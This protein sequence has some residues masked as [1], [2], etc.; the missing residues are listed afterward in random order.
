MRAFRA[1]TTWLV[2]L[3]R[4]LVGPCLPNI[5]TAAHPGDATVID[6]VNPLP[7]PPLINAVDERNMYVDAGILVTLR[8]TW[9]IAVKGFPLAAGWCFRRTLASSQPLNARHCLSDHR[10]FVPKALAPSGSTSYPV[11]PLLYSTLWVRRTFRASVEYSLGDAVGG[12]RHVLEQTRLGGR[13]SRNYPE[14]LEATNSARKLSIILQTDAARDQSGINIPAHPRCIGCFETP[15]RSFGV[16]DYRVVVSRRRRSEALG[17]KTGAYRGLEDAAPILPWQVVLGCPCEGYMPS[18]S[19]ALE[20][21]RD[22][23]PSNTASD[24]AFLPRCTVRAGHP[25]WRSHEPATFPIEGYLAPSRMSCCLCGPDA[26]GRISE[27]REVFIGPI[28]SSSTA[29]V[30]EEQ[31]RSRVVHGLPAG[32]PRGASVPWHA[33]RYPP[34]LTRRSRPDQ[35]G[36][37]NPHADHCI[38]VCGHGWG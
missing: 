12:L 1:T 20:S 23:L 25:P 33:T 26:R 38:H 10:S 32:P 17:V 15:I 6:G 5:G 7:Q 16:E 28:R 18:D 37:I 36:D 21:G 11:S 2:L 31:R 22:G 35:V 19:I 29:T 13:E 14:R 9:A 3:E 4:G 8:E 30:R 24:S 27:V 34:S